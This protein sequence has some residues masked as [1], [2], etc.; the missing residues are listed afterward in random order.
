MINLPNQSWQPTP[1]FRLAV[2]LLS[3]ARSGC[4]HRS[5]V[6]VRSFRETSL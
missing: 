2:F 4:T 6:A 1:G 3:L 5:T